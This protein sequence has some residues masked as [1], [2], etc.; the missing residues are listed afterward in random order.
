MKAT[1]RNSIR[2]K[3][4]IKQSL[5]ELLNKKPITD[6]TVTD[7]VTHANINRGTFYNHYNNPIDVVEEIKQELLDLLTIEL[8]KASNLKDVDA[9][10]DLIINHFKK[11]ENDYKKI[12]N[13]IPV[14]IIDEMK[15]TLIM[16]IR[17][18]NQSISQIDVCLIVNAICGTFIDYFK[19]QISF[20]YAEMSIKLKEFIKNVSKKA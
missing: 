2:S 13:S 3:E 15:K 9:F 12:I 1:Y 5:V 6:I 19:G 18:F 10:V 16:K 17:E 14:S 4:M 7:I 8:K 11:S 20:T